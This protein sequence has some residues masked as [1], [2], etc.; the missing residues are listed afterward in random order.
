MSVRISMAEVAARRRAGE[1]LVFVDARSPKA[2][3]A[4][5]DRLPGAIRIPPDDLEEHLADL[6]SGRPIVAYCT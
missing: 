3:G 4:A 5:V 1:Q 6:P 2:W